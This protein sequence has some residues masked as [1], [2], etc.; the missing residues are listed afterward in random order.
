MTAKLKGSDEAGHIDVIL[1]S[2][3]GKEAEEKK[4]CFEDGEENAGVDVEFKEL[5]LKLD[6]EV[7]PVFFVFRIFNLLLTSLYSPRLLLLLFSLLNFKPFNLRR[8]HSFV[9]LDR[10]E[11]IFLILDRRFLLQNERFVALSS[12]L[13]GEVISF[14]RLV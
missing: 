14:A 6:S 13:N 5:E 7:A 4:G 2:V 12:I 1:G 3:H 10:K 11:G 9:F 8:I